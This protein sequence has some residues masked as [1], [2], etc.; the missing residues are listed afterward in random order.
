MERLVCCRSPEVTSWKSASGV[1]ADAIAAPLEICEAN[2]H[3]CLLW[4]NQPKTKQQ[5][6]VTSNE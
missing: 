1:S 2:P 5:N 6:G 3:I 4:Y